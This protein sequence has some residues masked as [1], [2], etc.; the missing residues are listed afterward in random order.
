MSKRKKAAQAAPPVEIEDAP[1]A[2]KKLADY[3]QSQ[4]LQLSLFGFLDIKPADQ[5]RFSNTIRH[6]PHFRGNFIV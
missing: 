5:Q 6:I 1:E 2:I 4:P 3:E